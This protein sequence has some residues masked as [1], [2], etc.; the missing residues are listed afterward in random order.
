VNQNIGSTPQQQAVIQTF[1]GRGDKA[2]DI[3][4]KDTEKAPSASGFMLLAKNQKKNKQL[5]QAEKSMQGELH[6]QGDKK[7]MGIRGY[8]RGH[9]DTPLGRGDLIV[10]NLFF[11]KF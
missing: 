3:L 5:P 1:L 10:P 6:R 9:N 2:L 7:W 4:A 11:L 8:L